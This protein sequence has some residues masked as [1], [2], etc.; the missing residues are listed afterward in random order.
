MGQRMSTNR[1]AV[2][3][4]LSSVKAGLFASFVFLGGMV[5]QAG[6]T[7][8]NWAFPT[9][10]R[11]PWRISIELVG[12]IS[13]VIFAAMFA[14]TF[15]GLRTSDY[16]KETDV[17]SFGATVFIR[18]FSASAVPSVLL[19][20]WL[21]G[22]GDQPDPILMLM[23]SLS[24]G[25]LAFFYWPRTITMDEAGISQRSWFG[26]R[27][28]IP[29][30]EVEY[31]SYEPKRLTTFVVGPAV[32]TITHTLFHSDRALF[33]NLLEERTRKQVQI[34]VPVPR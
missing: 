7:L 26:F 14:S 13:G 3:V 27:R 6:R 33:Q 20:W 24:F 16:R 18:I 10:W 22:F 21:G 25:L 19:F 15:L 4:K 32:T 1:L 8:L 31:I 28:K 29:Y 11:M 2:Q 17:R 23:L 5:C 12:T 34:P 30:S 9:M